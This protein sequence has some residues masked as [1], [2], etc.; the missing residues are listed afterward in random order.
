MNEDEDEDEIAGVNHDD[1]AADAATKN[2]KH[3]QETTKRTKKNR[4]VY[5]HCVHG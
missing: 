2:S 1:V 3:Q 4:L 5:V